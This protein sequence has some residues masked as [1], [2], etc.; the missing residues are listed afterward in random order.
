MYTNF[1]TLLF[2]VSYAISQ[3]LV[4]YNEFIRFIIICPSERFHWPN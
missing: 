4:V 2:I 3:L 1:Y